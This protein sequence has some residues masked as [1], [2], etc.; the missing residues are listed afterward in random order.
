MGMKR[1]SIYAAFGDKRAL[2]VRALTEYADT[3]RAWLGG[4]LATPRSLPD[5]LRAVYRDARDY[6]LAGDDEPRGCFLLG[7]AVTE[8]RVTRRSG[9]SSNRP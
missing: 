8:A 2:Y 7:T 4:A 9:P 3:S 1:P 6:Y 5:A